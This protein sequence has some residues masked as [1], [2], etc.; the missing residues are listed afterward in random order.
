MTPKVFIEMTAYNNEEFVAE[1]IESIQAQTYT[2]WELFVANDG[3]TD[4]TGSIIEE[5]AKGDPRIHYYPFTK[6]TRGLGTGRCIELHMEEGACDY[7]ALLDSD[8]AWYPERLAHGVEFLEEHAE[9][10]AFFSWVDYLNYMESEH[11]VIPE[12]ESERVQGAPN[13]DRYQNL[14][15]WIS[16]GDY[17]ACTSLVRRDI[18]FELGGHNR[19]YTTCHDLRLWLQLFNRCPVYVST[20]RLVI[21]RHHRH[22]TSRYAR[23][24]GVRIYNDWFGVY[25]ELWSG[26]SAETFALAYYSVIPCVSYETE[27]E[28]RATQFMLANSITFKGRQRPYEQIAMDIYHDYRL[29]PSFIHLL[30][31]VYG[32]A[33]N[34]FIE[35]TGRAGLCYAYIDDPEDKEVANQTYKLSLWRVLTRL[36]DEDKLSDELME[37]LTYAVLYAAIQALPEDREVVYNKALMDKRAQMLADKRRRKIVILVGSGSKLNIASSLSDIVD[38]PDNQCYIGII[39][40]YEQMYDATERFEMKVLGMPRM[41]PIDIYDP[42]EHRV[43]FAWELGITAD[44]IY[45]IDCMEEDYPCPR[46]LTGYPLYTSMFCVTG[47]DGYPDLCQDLAGRIN[48]FDAVA[49]Y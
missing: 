6:N 26:M 9:Y 21:T 47:E 14:F 10:G 40:S 27:G 29:D 16:G 46:M 33:P 32:F 1:A 37:K 39:P 28:Y 8:D 20:E 3:S 23:D 2:N 4:A 43:R 12:E 5:H 38:N 22:N 41:E 13:R 48:L 45:Y 17:N 36:V 35:M 15:A 24:N 49:L 34:M 42:V 44:E 31:D 30:E 25:R 7:V 11:P 18:F 19:T